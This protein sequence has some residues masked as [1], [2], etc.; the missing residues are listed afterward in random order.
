MLITEDMFYETINCERKGIF[1]VNEART[2]MS[3]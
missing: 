2:I 3:Q 1:K